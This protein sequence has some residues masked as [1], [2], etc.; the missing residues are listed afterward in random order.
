L[1]DDI[2]KAF[3]EELEEELQSIPRHEK[4]FMGGDFNGHIGEKANG[5][6]RMHGGFGFG[7]RN[8][9]GVTLLDFALPFDLTIGNSL[10]MKKEEHLVTFRSGRSKTQIDYCLIRTNH[11][12]L[13][14]DYKVIPSECL[15]TQD[16]LLVMDLVIKS[17][18]AKKRSGGVARAKWWNLTRENATKLSE[19]IKLEAS[20]K[21]TEDA[22]EKWDGMTNCTHRS[23]QEVLGVSRGGGGRKSEVWWWNEEVREKV[24]K[25]QKAYTALN[26]CTSEEEKRVREATYKDVKKLAK[27]A[28]A[29]AKSNAY[30]R[31]YQK[32][33]TKEEEKDVFKL[34]RARKKKTRDLGCVRCIKGEDGKVLVEEAE[35]RERRQSYFSR[36]FNGENEY[37]PQVERGVQEGQLNVRVCSRISKEE[38]KEALRKMKS[39]KA[40]G[41]DFILV[42]IWKCLGEVG[43]DWL[44]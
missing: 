41:P 4:L 11:R 30:K 28:I 25:K 9:G 6:V 23:A 5:Y 29:L 34:A 13:C 42:E 31:L 16:R 22:D 21:L 38:V 27:K 7:E 3:W 19:K 2:K 36:L 35:I 32:L 17:F 40:V 1:P 37:S 20:W 26:S 8:S 33:E 12:S 44:T 39:E 18:K 10:F 15:G 14:K 24:K 43:L